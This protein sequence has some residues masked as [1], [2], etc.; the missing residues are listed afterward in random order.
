MRSNLLDNILNLINIAITNSPTSS[1][2][3]PDTVAYHEREIIASAVS[4]HA[5]GVR[6]GHPAF[7]AEANSW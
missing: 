3:R 5:S 6:W 2:N 4:I 1:A 7:F